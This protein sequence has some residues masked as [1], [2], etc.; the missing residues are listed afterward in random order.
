[1]YLTLINFSLLLLLF[2]NGCVNLEKYKRTPTEK[3]EI[4][5]IKLNKEVKK[6]DS[7]DKRLIYKSIKNEIHLYHQKGDEEYKNGYYHDAA[8]SYE[9]VNSRAT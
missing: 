3:K 1:M 4:R 2:L 8:K 5:I 6:L 7:H 9:L